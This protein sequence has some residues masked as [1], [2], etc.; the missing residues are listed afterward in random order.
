MSFLFD[1]PADRR[2][3]LE[4]LLDFPYGP[5][6]C[7]HVE[8]GDRHVTEAEIAGS[9][10]RVT[11]RPIYLLDLDAPEEVLI[12][13]MQK[14]TRNYVRR[15]EKTGLRFEEVTDVAFADE[16][17]EQLIDV[18]RESDIVPNYD[19]HE[20]RQM[21]EIMRPSGQLLMLRARDA[22]GTPIASSISLGRNRRAYAWGQA[23]FRDEAARHPIEPLMW[24]GMRRWRE[25]GALVYDL[26]A[27]D[28][29][30]TKFGAKSSPELHLR[31][32]RYPGLEFGRMGVR[33]AIEVRRRVAALL[34]RG[35]PV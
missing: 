28:F 5:L 16:Y 29:A 17:F 3:A 9:R 10:Y 21:I 33:A 15:A 8:V 27:G 25:R 24:E 6:G 18:Y 32:S 22:I 23:F 14:R 30:K 19:V 12:S 13:R 2:A 31:H 4:A 1:Q 7:A 35:A 20:V 11:N 26:D 34:R